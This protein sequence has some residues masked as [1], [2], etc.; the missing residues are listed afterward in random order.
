M[1]RLYR[2]LSRI[3]EISSK[4]ELLSIR[5]IINHAI[6]QEIWGSKNKGMVV[7][8]HANKSKSVKPIPDGKVTYVKRIKYIEFVITQN[9]KYLFDGQMLDD[10]KKYYV[11]AHCDP[12]ITTYD[13][14]KKINIAGVPFYIGKGTGDRAYD[15]NRNQGH[16]AKIR[17]VLRKC[18]SE[19][20]IVRIIRDNM[21]ELDALELESKLIYLFQ[22]VYENQ[23][24]GM[25]FNLDLGRRPDFNEEVEAAQQ[26]VITRKRCVEINAISNHQPSRQYQCHGQQ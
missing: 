11:Y 20:N 16:G 13:I 6:D 2:E 10:E 5:K 18:V 17:E 7:K 22:T 24:D 23:V 3:L 8:Q 9:W 14:S 25:L 15:L 21:S 1:K 26:K 12:T 4:S 19:R